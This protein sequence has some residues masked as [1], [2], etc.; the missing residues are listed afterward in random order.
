[1]NRKIEDL[2]KYI[3]SIKLE[4]INQFFLFALILVLFVAVVVQIAWKID[5]GPVKIWDEACTAQNAIEM[6]ENK[7]FLVVYNDGKPDHFN[8][9]PP[10]AVWT[11]TITYAIFGINV[12][13]IRLPNLLASVLL[14]LLFIYFYKKHLGHSIYIVATM[15]II[16][17]T[18]GFMTYHVARTGDP[19]A[20]LTF[21]VGFYAIVFFL[22]VEYYPK[23]RI[24]YLSLF[25]M[26]VVLA[27]YTKSIAGLSPLAGLFVYMLTQK[28]GRRLLK[29][30]R[31][32][33][34]ACG[35]IVLI[36]SY[37]LIRELYDPGYIDAVLKSEFGIISNPAVVKHPEKSFYFNYLYNDG[38]AP[39]FKYIPFILIPAIFSSSQRVRRLLL[40]SFLGAGFFLLG[41]SLVTLKNEWYIAPIFPFLWLLTGIGYA[42]LIRIMFG[43]IR[44]Y[45]YRFIAY[46]VVLFMLV[47]LFYPHYKDIFKLN[48]ENLNNY[49]YEPER[50]GAFLNR[51]K[52]EFPG[53]RNVKVF[54]TEHPR[55]LKYYA[56]KYYYK[57]GTKVD[58]YNYITEFQEDQNIIICQD[59]LQMQFQNTYHFEI[60]MEGKYCKLYQV[61]NSL[62]KEN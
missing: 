7:N 2:M 27:F 19:D 48:T 23:S 53:L 33:I 22:L 45:W 44:N 24:R 9:R 32:Y 34:T 50:A 54:S 10:M 5:E 60:L 11:K 17:C 55:Q 29:D 36:A 16:A 40:F 58:I 61:K 14:V 21:F 8:T 28:N 43:L 51:C 47:Y 3:G 1:M 41:N 52:L 57:D 15:I 56:K 26:G 20:M 12:F 30:Y 59:D 37:Y 42:E 25:A 13:A 4:K 46:A 31:L 38:F 6:L 49:I 18:R 35:A 39:F 62:S